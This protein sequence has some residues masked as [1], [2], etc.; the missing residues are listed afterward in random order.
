[1]YAFF[2]EI[3][4]ARGA[5]LEGA[6]SYDLCPLAESNIQPFLHHFVFDPNARINKME[7]W[8]WFSQKNPSLFSSSSKLLLAVFE[9]L[10]SCIRNKKWS[11]E[12]REE[13]IFSFSEH[14]LPSG[15]RSRILK[16]NGKT[17]SIKNSFFSVNARGGREIPPLSLLHRTHIVYKNNCFK[18]YFVCCQ[19]KSVQDSTNFEPNSVVGIDLNVGNMALSSKSFSYLYNLASNTQEKDERLLRRI[20]RNRRRIERIK[21]NGGS[22]EGASYKKAVYRIQKDYEKLKNRRLDRLHKASSYIAH[23]YEY[24]FFENLKVKRLVKKGGVSDKKS[25]AKK[26]I[27]KIYGSS[28]CSLITMFKYKLEMEGKRYSL[29]NPYNTSITCSQC[30]AISV[31]KTLKDRVFFCD[32]CKSTMNRDINASLN[33]FRIGCK[34][35]HLRYSLVDGL[36]KISGHKK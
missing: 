26:L 4:K 15:Q 24:V 14:I 10:L 9:S 11:G 6:Y 33:I 23:N 19:S 20:V 32:K 13:N 1:M 34:E 7:F 16:I 12:L 2:Q 17:Y 36:Y 5:V 29:V 25:R 21:K 30:G 31:V 18:I 35:N 22:K 27:D 8:K 3:K 28:F